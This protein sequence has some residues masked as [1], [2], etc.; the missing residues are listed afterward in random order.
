[1]IA[2]NHRSLDNL[3]IQEEAALALRN[4]LISQAEMENIAKAY[5]VNLYSP[6]LFIRIG[7]LLLTAVIILMVFGLF[8]LVLVDS[9]SAGFGILCFVVSLLTYGGLEMLI[10]EKNITVRE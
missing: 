10:R 1:M 7:L 4:N 6:N 5:P 2:Y 3:V 8:C 9:S